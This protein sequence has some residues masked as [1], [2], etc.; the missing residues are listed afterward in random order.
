MDIQVYQP[1]GNLLFKVS[2]L[3][4]AFKAP[5]PG[6]D[7]EWESNELLQGLTTSRI[8]KG[9]VKSVSLK[10]SF[11]GPKRKLTQVYKIQLATVYQYVVCVTPSATV[12]S[13]T[14][15]TAT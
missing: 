8:L 4:D 14:A 12:Y 2:E 6:Q 11:D 5:E 13:I 15:R 10:A 1:N 7:W 9:F 3:P